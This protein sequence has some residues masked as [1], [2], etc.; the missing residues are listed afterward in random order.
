MKLYYVARACNL[1]LI[2]GPFRTEEQAEKAR[3]NY[4]GTIWGNCV[5]VSRVK[6]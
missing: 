1:H 4:D 5:I 3:Q 2:C 6:K